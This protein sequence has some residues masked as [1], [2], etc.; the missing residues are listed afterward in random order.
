[1][2]TKS[3]I[4]QLIQQDLKHNQLLMALRTMG[5]E[6]SGLYDLDLMEIVAQLLEIPLAQMEEFTEIYGGYLDSAHTFP[7]S[8]ERREL[9]NVAEECLNKVAGICFRKANI[10]LL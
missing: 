5:F 9:L 4:I 3:L 2:K 10:K 7:V 6:D 8:F 1:M